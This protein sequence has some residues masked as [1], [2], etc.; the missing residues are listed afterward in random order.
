[1]KPF[2]KWVGGKT[3]LLP[4]IRELIGPGPIRNYFEP[5]VGG[6]AVFFDLVE[7]GIS[8]A[9]LSDVNADLMYTYY[10]IAT[11]IAAFHDDVMSLAGVDYFEIRH[12][13][14]SRSGHQTGHQTSPLF[15]ALCR[16]SF[17]GL[18]RVNSTGKMN[19]PVGRDAKKRPY[20]LSQIDW[21]HIQFC[22][23]ALQKAVL[24]YKPWNDVP[25]VPCSEFRE[26]DVVVLDPPYCGQFNGYAPGL[27]RLEEHRLLVEWARRVGDQGARVV[28]CGSYLPDTVKI[29]GEPT[30]IC[31]NNGT[32]G[33]GKRGKIQEALWAFGPERKQ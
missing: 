1:M 10:R 20:D 22:S 8:S 12:L 26:D 4:Q 31:D 23:G 2:I 3:R 33:V 6:G 28:L 18:W 14:N 25:H 17:N 11:D 30:I 9:Y 29:Y 15:F 24:A 7:S 16:L 19:V 5:F 21:E 32:F 13:Y 27:F